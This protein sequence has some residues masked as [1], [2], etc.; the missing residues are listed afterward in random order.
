MVISA[1]PFRYNFSVPEQVVDALCV[2][3]FLGETPLMHAARAPEAG[4]F[5]VVANKLPTDQVRDPAV[6]KLPRRLERFL[7]L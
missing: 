7:L 4:A 3:N 1:L 5:R 2:K 6:K